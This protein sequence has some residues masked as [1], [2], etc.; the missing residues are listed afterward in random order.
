MTG[1][2]TKLRRIENGFIQQSPNLLKRDF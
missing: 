1:E 2:M